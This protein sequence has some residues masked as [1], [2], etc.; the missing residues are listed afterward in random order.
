MTF[1]EQIK[2]LLLLASSGPTPVVKVKWDPGANETPIDDG[3]PAF[4]SVL[5]VDRGPEY[6][7]L[8]PQGLDA[9]LEA[10]NLTRE[11]FMHRRGRDWGSPEF[12][13]LRQNDDLRITEIQ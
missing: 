1:A 10:L 13:I 2:A 3:R 12:T 7:V 9:L 5:S 8:S 4:L 6:R 11:D